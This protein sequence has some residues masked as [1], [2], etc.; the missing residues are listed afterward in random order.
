MIEF[1]YANRNAG[2]VLENRNTLAER[3]EMFQQGYWIRIVLP[4]EFGR[5]AV[6]VCSFVVEARTLPIC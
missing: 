2:L 5:I 4:V 3:I 6:L 1:L